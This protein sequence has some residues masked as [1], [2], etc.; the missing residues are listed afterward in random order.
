MYIQCLNFHS[1]NVEDSSISSVTAKILLFIRN[2]K[3][4]DLI[5]IKCNFCFYYIYYY[6]RKKIFLF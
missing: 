6:N 1:R 3:R 5:Y 2:K 4:S